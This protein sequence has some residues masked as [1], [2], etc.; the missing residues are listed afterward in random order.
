MSEEIF[1]I[2]DV[3]DK[4]SMNIDNIFT[5]VERLGEEKREIISP[6]L[7]ITIMVPTTI[8]RQR[9]QATRN[10]FFIFLTYSDE[11]FSTVTYNICKE[12]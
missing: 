7:T 2:D 10:L 11:S 3:I 8:K 4:L 6:N 1:I 12:C 5:T 9:Y